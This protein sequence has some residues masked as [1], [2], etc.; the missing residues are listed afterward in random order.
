MKQNINDLVDGFFRGVVLVLGSAFTSLFILLWQ[1]R[2]GLF[3]LYRRLR[4]KSAEQVAPRVFL[5]IALFTLLIAPFSIGSFFG[6]LGGDSWSDAAGMVFN[7][8]KTTPVSILAASLAAMAGVAIVE[9]F[10]F[11]IGLVVMPKR[12]DVLAKFVEYAFGVELF[13]IVALIGLA[14]TLFG[15]SADAQFVNSSGWLSSLIHVVSPGEVFF[16]PS[17]MERMLIWFYLL[18]VPVIYLYSL[19]PISVVIGRKWKAFTPK[20]GTTAPVFVILAVMFAFWASTTVATELYQGLAKDRTPAVAPID[21]ALADCELVDAGA[22]TR[23]IHTEGVV[24]NHGNNGVLMS[25]ATFVMPDTVVRYTRD[26]AYEPDDGSSGPI[27]PSVF[28]F[29]WNVD[30]TVLEPNRAGWIS[31]DFPLTENQENA[32]AK[33]SFTPDCAMVTKEFTA[34]V[35]PITLKM[36]DGLHAAPVDPPHYAPIS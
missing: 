36:P 1:P 3:R 13:V 34:D 25:R 21:V 20:F 14:D 26:V 5:F 22:P 18:I 9:L 19:F 8:L 31:M 16:K 28:S 29:E 27:A 2:Q 6:A 4:H 30:H 10:L 35:E 32:I 15:H 12:R 33:T 11:L 7:Q 23:H 17:A 24:T